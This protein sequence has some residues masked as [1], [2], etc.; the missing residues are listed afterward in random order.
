MAVVAATLAALFLAL[1][2]GGG[3]AV[4]CAA[5]AAVG[6]PAFSRY[7]AVFFSP[8]PQCPTTGGDRG[9]G[10]G[11]GGPGDGAASLS[12]SD[13]VL[14]SN[15]SWNSRSRA[16]EEPYEKNHGGDVSYPPSTSSSS[17]SPLWAVRPSPGKGFGLFATRRIPK[18]TR[19][20]VE[21][22]L[23]VIDPPAPLPPD[24]S[25]ST[26]PSTDYDAHRRFAAMLARIHAGFDGLAPAD[27]A[28]YAALHEHRFPGEPARGR[29]FYI[30]RSN[31]Y[32]IT[33]V[34]S[35]SSSSSSSSS[36]FSTDQKTTTTRWGMFPLMARINHSCRPNVANLWVP[37]GDAAEEEDSDDDKAATYGHHVVWTTRDVAPGEELLIS[38]VNLLQDTA[39]RQRSLD[40]YGF[41]CGC[42]VCGGNYEG[43]DDDDADY[44]VVDR[45]R[46]RA[47]AL[48]RGLEAFLA[49]PDAD[50]RDPL[51]VAR[52][53]D[54]TDEL[55]QILT[56]FVVDE[57]GGL[58]GYLPRVYRLAAEL[59]SLAAATA[60]TVPEVDDRLRRWV[61]DEEALL[62]AIGRPQSLRPFSH[63]S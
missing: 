3:H 16:D 24:T 37:T 49:E 14:V 32:T 40:Q 60:R 26:S 9:G 48:L 15:R 8:V 61:A 35:R 6:T 59:G 34:V 5:A 36:S 42:P 41:R 17:S 51:R 54:D 43:E 56:D 1:V 44:V 53:V 7:D 12:A 18:H 10:G 30:F 20:L 11:G 27:Q 52:Y 38:Y 62:R 13:D 2:L 31:A 22:P 45:R 25:S 57:Q 4:V 55:L 39:G 28:R 47:G 33:P 19:V 46:T 63:G 58:A 21:A 29:L 23:F 50:R